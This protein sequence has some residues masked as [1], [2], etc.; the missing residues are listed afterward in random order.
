MRLSRRK[1]KG[2]QI[3]S[4]RKR[5]PGR[6]RKL[7][8]YAKKPGLCIGQLLHDKQ[9]IID[10][11]DYE[12]VKGY[13]WRAGRGNYVYTL[14]TEEGERRRIFLHRLIMGLKNVSW[15]EQQVDHI[16]GNPLNNCRNNL[17][18]ATAAE[19]QINKKKPR[20]DNTTGHTGITYKDGK[21]IA[22]LN[23]HGHKDFLGAFS[24]MEEAIKIRKEAE[25]ILYGEYS[26][27]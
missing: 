9:F 13:T 26:P 22:T 18:L 1:A 15:K 24:T 16:D 6:P 14:V 7:N 3:E 27:K 11:A 8:V 12:V 20:R 25:E 5:K 4:A 19:N 2:W 17:R 23:Y 10:S 21:W